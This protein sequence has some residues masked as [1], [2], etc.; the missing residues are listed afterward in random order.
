MIC[1]G[2]KYKEY[3]VDV[4]MKKDYP[5]DDINRSRIK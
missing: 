3:M 5:A 4:G 2:M 1:N